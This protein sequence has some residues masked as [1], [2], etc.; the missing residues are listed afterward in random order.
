MMKKIVLALAC[1]VF[2]LASCSKR[3]DFSNLD[4]ADVDGEIMLSLA[5]AT[6]TFP[7]LLKQ[8]NVDTLLNFDEDGGMHFLFNYDLENVVDG[9]KILVYKDT[10]VNHSFTIQNPYPFVL[11]E[12][13]DTTIVFTHAV[14]LESDHIGVQKADI[15]SGSFGF[16]ISSN[17]T[18]LNQV[19]IRSP[20][21][22]DVDGNELQLVYNPSVGQN[23]LD[24]A[25]MHFETLAENTIHFV[26]EVSFTMQDNTMPEL[27]FES[28]LHVVDLHVR[29]MLGWV[30]NYAS[31]RTLDTTFKM[32]SD[33]IHGVAEMCAAKIRLRERNGFQLNAR[34]QIDT[35]LLW[36]EGVPPYQVFSETPTFVDIPSTSEFTDVLSETVRGKLNMTSDYAYASG[37]FVLNPDGMEDVV[38]VS[39]TSTIDVKVDV[40]IP[41]SFKVD[42]LSCI[43]TVE[44]NFANASLPEV[45][46]EITL[47]FDFLTDLP[48]NLSV[49]AYAYDSV[50]A[51][52]MDTLAVNEKLQGS[53]DGSQVESEIV[54]QAIDDRVDKILK[55][56]HIILNF[57]LDTDSHDVML[58]RKQNLSFD[59]KAA[60]KYVGN[61]EFS[62]SDENE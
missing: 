16:E 1:F 28:T 2:L 36:G 38:S 20:E 56:D 30:K 15:R 42:Q 26:Y 44:M 50:N 49:S 19:V 6:Y 21:F 60:V 33:K 61:V 37:V 51:I 59:V 17:I 34:L 58:N 53:F 35:A 8:F 55:S 29:E 3:Y 32:F 14:S 9:E 52:V 27:N 40:D 41:C 7:D 12:P 18:H 24:L 47:D 62:K 57:L 45:I 54:I 11:P 23:S 46:D 10:D 5:S 39:D 13:I 4:S 43:D 31:S 22:V 48:F 25:G